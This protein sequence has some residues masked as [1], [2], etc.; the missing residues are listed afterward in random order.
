MEVLLWARDHL[1]GPIA[2]A[3]ATSVARRIGR[4]RRD[5]KAKGP[6][7]VVRVL[8]A[9][10]GSELARVSVADELEET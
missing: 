6:P 9:P 5:R 8:Y 2:L 3:L 4:W 10:D 1:A 7:P